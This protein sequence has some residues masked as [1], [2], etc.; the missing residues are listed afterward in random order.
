MEEGMELHGDWGYQ[1]MRTFGTIWEVF[2]F[3]PSQKLLERSPHLK[4]VSWPETWL[5]RSYGLSHPPNLLKMVQL[6]T[7]LENLRKTHL[8]T[9]TPT[10]MVVFSAWSTSKLARASMSTCRLCTSD[11]I[12]SWG[13]GSEQICV[14]SR[15]DTQTHRIFEH[16]F[17]VA[18]LLPNGSSIIVLPKDQSC[19]QLATG[20]E[21]TRVLSRT[22]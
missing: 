11:L 15:L 8:L 4:K 20:V 3:I 14:G 19:K 18:K 6:S 17:H 22:V 7:V 16:L 1:M 10:K 2:H 12:G 13:E 21:C 5:I 9:K